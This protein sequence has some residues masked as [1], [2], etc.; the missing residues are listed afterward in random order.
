M[1]VRWGFGVTVIYDPAP[2]YVTAGNW[3][4]KEGAPDHLV[5]PYHEEA[6]RKFFLVT[7]PWQFSMWHTLRRLNNAI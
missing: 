1:G 5:L 2:A 6:P 3:C 4:R 7:I